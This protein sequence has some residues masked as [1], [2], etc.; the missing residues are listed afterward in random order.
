MGAFTNG[1]GYKDVKDS[2]NIQ[3]HHHF[4]TCLSEICLIIGAVFSV[5]GKHITSYEVKEGKLMVLR[6]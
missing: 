3:L 4:C 5:A 6:V 2:L 1:M